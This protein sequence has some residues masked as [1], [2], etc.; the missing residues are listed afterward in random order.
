VASWRAVR[1]KYLLGMSTIYVIHGAVRDRKPSLFC[2]RSF[3]DFETL[4][5]HL[6][7]RPAKYVSLEDALVGRGDAL[8]ID[9]ATVAAKT[10]AR[11]ACAHGHA[12]TLFVN[13]SNVITQRTY[14]F[15]ELNRLLDM[16]G[17]ESVEFDSHKFCFGSPDGKKLF[18]QHAKNFLC[19]LPAETDRSALIQEIARLLDVQKAEVPDDLR[20]VSVQDLLDLQAVGVD[21]QNHGWSH[22]HYGSLSE[23]DRILEI[24]NGAVWLDG[25]LKVETRYFAVP[26]GNVMPSP[27]GPS[28][29]FA[30]WFTLNS[31]WRAGRLN[32]T[33]WNR[34]SLG[35]GG[36]AR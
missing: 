24:E 7:D 18:R 17:A 12:V 31:A 16:T 2:H 6:I 3:H 10:S 19:R 15:I 32:T 5:R 8:T 14:F 13:P 26:F 29:H 20:T 25:T 28:K 4:Q 9:D 30:I 23:A 27:E 1:A 11:L 21:I 22:A 34:R 33:A 35:L 36:A